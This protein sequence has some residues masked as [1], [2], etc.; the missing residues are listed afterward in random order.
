MDDLIHCNQST[1]RI[2]THLEFRRLFT[3]EERELS[4]ELEATFESNAALTAAQKRTLRSGYKDF[5]AAST[6]NLDDPA[7]PPMLMLY[8]ALGIV[9]VDRATEILA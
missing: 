7:I 9:A 1:G 3:Q 4:D 8:E 6:V 5:N 2:L